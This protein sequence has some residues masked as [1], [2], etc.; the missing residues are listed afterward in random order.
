MLSDI[1]HKLSGLYL[2]MAPYILLGLFFVGLLHLF[3]SKDFVV[4]HVGRESLASVVKA[5]LLG[6]PLPLCSCGVIPTAVFMAKNGAS[7]S[8]VVSFL[9]STPQTGIDSI[10]AT[11]G[12]LGWVFAIYRPVA[13]FVGGISGGI[14]VRLFGRPDQDRKQESCCSSAEEEASC[15]CSTEKETSC[16][17][18]AEKETSCCSS[19]EKPAVAPGLLQRF[20]HYA[21]VEFLDDISVHF[22]IGLAVSAVIAWAVPEDFFSRHAFVN[23]LPGM[24]LM[25]LVSVPMYICATASIP[26]GITLLL[27]GL[28]PGVVFVFL[29]VGPMTNAASLTVL[30][31]VFSRRAIALYLASSSVFAILAGLLLDFFVGRFNLEI[32]PSLSHMHGTHRVSMVSLVCAIVLG[33][34]LLLSLAR[35]IGQT[36]RLRRRKTE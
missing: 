11:Y 25:I 6:V 23:G 4:R 19:S 32:K 33:V 15:S 10:I 29:A 31:S 14:I 9:I 22:L 27:K 16:C 24:L 21:F 26:I 36:Y 35:K 30:L 13:A 5:S 34:F 8:A 17:S 2:D 18:S 3:L 28:S 20:Y 1:I 7:R 12:L